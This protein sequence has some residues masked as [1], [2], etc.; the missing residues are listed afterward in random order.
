M[1]ALS[2]VLVVDD[3][4]VVRHSYTRSLANSV[5]SVDAV[6]NAEA[7]LL[8]MQQSAFDVVLLDLRMPGLDGM[9]ALRLLKR[10]WPDSEVIIITGY[11][12]LDTAKQAVSLGAYDYLAKPTEPRE[13]VRV[14]TSAAQH[15]RWALHRER[16]PVPVPGF[17]EGEAS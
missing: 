15:K 7:A 9:A 11:P 14:T 2:R 4:A 16:H 5:G 10:D 13:L 1:D 3:D 17:F 12:E 8:R 6:D